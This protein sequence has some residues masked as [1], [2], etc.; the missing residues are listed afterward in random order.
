MCHQGRVVEISVEELE[1]L[2]QAVP[3][4]HPAAQAVVMIHHT[5]ATGAAVVGPQELP[6]GI[7]VENVRTALAEKAVFIHAVLNVSQTRDA[8]SEIVAERQDASAVPGIQQMEVTVE[9]VAVAPC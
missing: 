6:F 8:V 4:R 9:V 1:V 2:S 7:V 3:G 5:P